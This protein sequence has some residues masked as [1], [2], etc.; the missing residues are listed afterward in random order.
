MGQMFI[1]PDETIT[2]LTSALK[3]LMTLQRELRKAYDEQDYSPERQ[4]TLNQLIAMTRV[5]L[6]L[7]EREVAKPWRNF[8]AAGL[9]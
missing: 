3:D 2:R 9:N 6:K 1:V 7:A 8:D 4:R 5:S